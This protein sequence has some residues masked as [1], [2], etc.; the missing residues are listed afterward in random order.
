MPDRGCWCGGAIAVWLLGA[1]CTAPALGQPRRL[2]ANEAVVV[3]PEP[4]SVV[5]PCAATVYPAPSGWHL[6]FLPN[7]LLYPA[8]LAGGR[9]PRFASQWVHQRDQGVLWDAA[10]GGRVGMLRFGSADD[11]WPEGFQLDIEGAVFPRM[12]LERDRDLVSA[13]FRF[14]VPLTLRLGK[15]EAKF[16]YDHL[17]SHL[18]D[19]YMETF[20]DAERVNYV[21]DGMIFGLAMW[22]CPDWRFYTEA[23]WAFH[24]D[25]GSEALEFQFGVDYSSVER[26]GFFGDPFFAANGRLREDLDFG[27]AITI[28]AGRQWRGQSGHLLR[29]GA[30]YFNGKS[31]QYQFANEHEEQIGVGMWYDF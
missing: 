12:S 11:V 16:A 9:E 24:F 22:P 19:E 17:S 28:Q 8:Y 14:G 5:V 26:S 25:G 15:W 31:E 18:G 29:V 1:L 2:P 20:P 30:H 21:R 7:G 3:W 10:L 23:A 27:G 13:D 4:P 6:Q